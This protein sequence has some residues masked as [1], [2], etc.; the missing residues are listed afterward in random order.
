MRMSVDLPARAGSCDAVT[1]RIASHRPT[2][3]VPCA[4][5]I[6]PGGPGP[7]LVT[8]DHAVTALSHPD[9]QAIRV[10]LPQPRSLQGWP[11]RAESRGSAS[12]FAIRSK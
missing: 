3:A 4:W 10:G 2:L 9:R 1:K 8:A 12:R 5:L 11:N 7:R 6:V